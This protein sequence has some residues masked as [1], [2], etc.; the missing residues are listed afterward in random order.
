M[1]RA[2]SR[3]SEDVAD[4]GVPEF[5][6]WAGPARSTAV[7]ANISALYLMSI[8]PVQIPGNPNTRCDVAGCPLISPWSVGGADAPDHGAVVLTRPGLRPLR[9][10]AMPRLGLEIA[11]RLVHHLVELDEEFDHEAV[12]IGVVDRD[13]V[14]RAVP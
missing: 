9:K 1:V 11:Q 13:V 14:T 10:V 12:G 2:A 6:A 4:D 8:V 5:C 7:A 3:E